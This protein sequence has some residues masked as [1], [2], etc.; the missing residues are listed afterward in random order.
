MIRSESHCDSD[1][2][3]PPLK[4]TNSSD[5]TMVRLMCVGCYKYIRT[6]IYG[7]GDLIY[8]RS[9]DATSQAYD[10]G[11]IILRWDSHTES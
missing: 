8:V 9:G 4:N 6:E 11:I 1:L 10:P 5:C 2:T 7:D 3:D